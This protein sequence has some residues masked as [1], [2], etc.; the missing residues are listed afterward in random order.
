MTRQAVPIGEVLKTV[1]RKL[2]LEKRVKEAVIAQEWE[3]I[4][5]AKIA[6]HSKPVGVRGRTLIVNVDSSVWLSELN[7]YFKDTI[8]DQVRSDFQESRIKRIRF[9]IGEI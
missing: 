4:V 1:V 6:G 3:R 7:N 2:G 5:G 9:R 8:V